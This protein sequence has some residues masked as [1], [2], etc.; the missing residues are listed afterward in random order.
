MNLKHL[1]LIAKILLS[2]GL[3]W[4]VSTKLDFS[5]SIG[6]I[7]KMAA[8]WAFIIVLL[9]FLQ[10]AASAARY[11]AF[12]GLLETRASY[13]RCMDATLIGYFFSQT[14]VSFVGGDAMRTFRMAQAG[15]SVKTSVKAVILDRA[16]GFVG[17]ITIV[18]LILPFLLPRL[19]D[20]TIRA[21][22]VG[23]V[24]AAITSAIGVVVLA[25]L[26]DAVRRF[27][28][29]SVISDLSQ[30]VVKRL[31]TLRGIYA[32]VFLSIVI[33]LMNCL[34]FYT[35]AVGLAVNVSL[36]DMLVLL[37]PVFFLSMLPI[38]ISG[39]G[40]REGATV[41]ALGLA[42]VSAADSLSISICFGLTL[43]AISLPGGMIW[44]ISHKKPAPKPSELSSS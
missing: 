8:G 27:K 42:G 33:N 37:P 44:L 21:S 17:L 2:G 38:S 1:V 43:I 3:I 25:H 15:I 10:L 4:F 26:P 29:L 32:F 13:W 41:V 36:F 11:H 18:L 31:G 14:V 12:L 6:Q 16:S 5:G 39:W 28:A 40:V 30:R 23:V 20:A 22:V 7:S 24:L 35:I 9:F 19:P 34:I